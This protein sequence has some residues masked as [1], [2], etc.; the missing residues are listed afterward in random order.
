MKEIFKLQSNGCLLN[1]TKIY[2]KNSKDVI[3]VLHGGPG[4]GAGPVMNLPA[5]KTLEKTFSM[6]YFDQ[7]GS[8]KSEYDL[9]KGLTI[10]QITDDVKCV[11]EYTNNEFKNQ[12]VYLWGGSFGGLLGLLFLQRY[13]TLVKKSIISSPAIFISNPYCIDAQEKYFKEIFS[14]FLPQNIIN[15]YINNT[16]YNMV[17]IMSSDEFSQWIHENKQPIKGHEAIWHTYAMHEWFIDCDMRSSIKDIKIKTLFLMGIEDSYLPANIL[18]DAI[19]QYPN[20]NVSLK[21]FSP[22]GHGVFDD[23]K[24]EFVKICS[25]FYLN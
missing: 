22:C 5:F 15:K 7:R 9:T 13:P 19:K 1:V 16:S 8:G 10:E 23:C 11:V 21:T 25:N 20:K 3:V 4:S 6:V 24:D 17:D 12:N 18:I 14:Q 2:N